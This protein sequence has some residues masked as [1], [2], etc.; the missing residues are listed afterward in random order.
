VEKENNLKLED[1]REL[2]SEEDSN[3]YESNRKIIP[4]QYRPIKK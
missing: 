4:K 2:Y 3:D 1:I